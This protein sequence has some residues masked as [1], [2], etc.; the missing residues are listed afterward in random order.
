MQSCNRKLLFFFFRSFFLYSIRI[1]FQRKVDRKGSSFSFFTDDI[2]L[3]IHFFNQ[4]LND[5][6]T[7][8][9]TAE[10]RTCSVFFLCERFKHMLLEFFTH[11]LSG[12]HTGKLIHCIFFTTGYLFTVQI[13][14]SVFTIIFNCITCDIQHDLA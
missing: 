2:N 14:A 9:C 5:G 1:D 11:T 3:S 10:S 6:K 8:S 4:L 13:K 12:I 7:K